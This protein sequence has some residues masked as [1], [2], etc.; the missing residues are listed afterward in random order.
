MKC[1]NK[2]SHVFVM[3]C[4]MYCT[5]A[6]AYAETMWSVKQERSTSLIRVRSVSSRP[7]EF[8]LIRKLSKTGLHENASPFFAFLELRNCSEQFLRDPFFFK[9][10]LKK[11]KEPLFTIKNLCRI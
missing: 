11:S 5:L 3:L 10:H 8:V 6:A 9:E 1:F 4:Y 2:L 7:S